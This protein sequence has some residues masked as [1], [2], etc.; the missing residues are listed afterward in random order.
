[1]GDVFLYFV[2]WRQSRGDFGVGGNASKHH[3]STL[4]V[5]WGRFDEPPMRDASGRLIRQG[6]RCFCACNLLCM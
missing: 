6:V 2:L 1:M 4:G 3:Q 5:A